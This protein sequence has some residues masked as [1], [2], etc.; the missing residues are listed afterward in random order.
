MAAALASASVTPD[1]T[2]T[3]SAR[4]N[5]DTFSASSPSASGDGVATTS[6]IV[7]GAR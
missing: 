3:T 1:S 7:S 2:V 5:R 6:S 4:A